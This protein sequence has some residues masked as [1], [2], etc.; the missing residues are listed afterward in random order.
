MIGYQRTIEGILTT[1]PQESTKL[2]DPPHQESQR[3]SPS[4]KYRK[5]KT[6]IPIRRQNLITKFTPLDKEK[7]I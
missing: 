6:H 1:F 7:K 3:R 4:P 2:T 5:S